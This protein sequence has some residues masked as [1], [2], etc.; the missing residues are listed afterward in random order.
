MAVDMVQRAGRVVSIGL[1]GG[2]ETPVRFDVLV[3]RSINTL[4]GLGQAGDV[5][6]AMRLIN[7]GKFP[8]HKINNFHHR[9]KEAA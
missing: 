8:F 3:W 5:Q 2:K 1:S 7:S 6:D 9:L 4:C